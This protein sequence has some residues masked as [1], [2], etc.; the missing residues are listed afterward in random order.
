MVGVTCGQPISWPLL[1]FHGPSDICLDSDS[2]SVVDTSTIIP[3]SRHSFFHAI[4]RLCFLV[5]PA[6]CHPGKC[7][8]FEMPVGEFGGIFYIK[9]LAFL[10]HFHNIPDGFSVSGRLQGLW[11]VVN[12]EGCCPHYAFVLK[13]GHG[14]RHCGSKIWKD[15]QHWRALA[16]N[17]RDTSPIVS[18]RDLRH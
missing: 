16:T 9:M 8:K 2:K 5:D 13:M 17:S 6:G 1:G 12:F 14:G 7:L 3:P 4:F 11:M 18:P 15:E 10:S